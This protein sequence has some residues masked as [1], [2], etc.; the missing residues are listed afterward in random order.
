V[1][2]SVVI[3]AYNEANRI[4]KTLESV[5]S[6]FPGAEIIVIDDGSADGT[7]KVASGYG[8]MVQRHES[9]MG[10]GAAVRTGF[11]LASGGVV[12]FID[13]DGST[14]MSD[15]RRVFDKVGEWDV[16]VASRRLPG[17]VLPVDQPGPRKLA[18]FMLRMLVRA[19]LGLSIMD[20]QC[21]CK[22][23]SRRAVDY[24]LPKW[25]SDG[26]EFDMELL[27]LCRIGGFKVLETPVKWTDVKESKVSAVRDGLRMLVRLMQIR[28]R[29]H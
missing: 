29:H 26:F 10:K 6:A 25:G 14:D 22:A 7:S 19:V 27:Y 21:G 13:A 4:G 17:S 3:P 18:G 11:R 9:N 23:M 5:K 2:Y 1:D 8:V 20:T 12:G 24:V 15:A 16:V 28:L